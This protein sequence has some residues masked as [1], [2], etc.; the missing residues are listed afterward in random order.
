MCGK[1]L[2]V[3]ARDKHGEFWFTGLDAGTY[4]VVEPGQD[5]WNL[6]TKQPTQDPNSRD[7]GKQ[8]QHQGYQSCRLA[9]DLG[10]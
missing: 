4:E 1:V 8:P 6:S 10:H 7:D 9:N 3:Q 5:D 2:A